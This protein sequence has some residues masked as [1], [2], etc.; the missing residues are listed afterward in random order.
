M[1]TEGEDILQV[2]DGGDDDDDYHHDY[3]QDYEDEDDK[4]VDPVDAEID[5]VL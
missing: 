1:D 4:D 2:D 3:H 5:D